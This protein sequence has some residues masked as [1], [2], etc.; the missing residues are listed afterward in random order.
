MAYTLSKEYLWKEIGDRVVVLHFESGRYFSL[1]DSGSLIW[2]GLL[3]NQT[4]DQIVAKLCA[5]FE[6]GEEAARE[7]ISAMTR[8]FLQKEFLVAD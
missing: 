3:E 8:D 2:K 4:S 5:A 1:N 6:V 7:D